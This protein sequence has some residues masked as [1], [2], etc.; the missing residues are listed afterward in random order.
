[1]TTLD[2]SPDAEKVQ[3]EIFRRMEPE[4]RLPVRCPS[5]RDLP[6]PSGGRNPETPS[7]LRR[8]TSQTGGDP[9]SP[10]GRPFSSGLSRRSRHSAMTPEDALRLLLSKLDE[11]EIPYMITGSFASNIQGFPRAT[12]DADVV[13]EVEQGGFRKISRKLSAS[14]FYRSSEAAMDALVRQQMFNVVHLETGFKVDLIIRKSRP[15][16][17]MEFSRRQPAFYLGA[18]RWFATAEDTILA[19]LEWSRMVDSER[20]FNDALNVAKIQRDNLDR[21]YLEKWATELDVMDLL[22]RRKR[23]TSWMK[24]RMKIMSSKIGSKSFP[25]AHSMKTWNA[26]RAR[27]YSR[28]TRSMSPS[29]R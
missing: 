9:M 15:F 25:A 23:S 29:E 1:M 21:V 4:K 3:I 6:H 28:T 24:C 2:T 16:S 20:Q 19:K 10:S 5:L 22:E 18:N 14:A 11:F 7:K 26:C 17:R 8:R 12:Q 13:I 27:A